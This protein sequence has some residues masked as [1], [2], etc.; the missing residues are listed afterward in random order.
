MSYWDKFCESGKIEDYL[1]FV[2]FEKE[3][4]D[5]DYL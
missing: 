3:E 5:H 1:N 2:Q 4:E